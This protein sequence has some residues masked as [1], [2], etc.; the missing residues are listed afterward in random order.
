MTPWTFF[1][2]LDSRG[3]NLIRCWLDRLPA[4]VSA[5]VDVRIRFMSAMKTWP[6]QYV[7]ALK[8]WPGLFELKVVSA[9]GQYRL[10][11]F[12]GPGRGGFT[13]VLGAVE[14]GRLP[15]RIL[16]LAENNR[17]IVL[18]DRSRIRE[19]EYQRTVVPEPCDRS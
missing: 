10:L 14:K 15:R 19:H 12:Y 2:F 7:S 3:N 1:D 8:G 13:L 17:Q 4:K 6:E 5:K 11:G 9:G 16:E 18:V